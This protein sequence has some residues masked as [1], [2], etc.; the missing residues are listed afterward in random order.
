MAQLT[1]VYDSYDAVNVN[2]ESLHDIVTALNPAQ[3]PFLSMC[4]S[5][6]VQNTYHEWTADTL[7]G[8]AANAQIEGDEFTNTAITAP[9]RLFNYTQISSYVVS[10]TGTE[11][12]VATVGEDA[13]AYNLM[14]YGQLLKNDMEA[15]MLGNQAA[16]AG[17][18]N[19]V[20]ATRT[21]R[22][23][24]AWVPEANRD[25]N[26]TNGAGTTTQAATDGTTGQLRA[27]TEAQ[28]LNV[29]EAIY[30][31]GANPDTVIMHPNK[32]KIFS[33]FAGNGTRVFDA[34]SQ[35]IVAAVRIYVS[36]YG[37]VE[38][39]VDR[40]VRPTSSTVGRSVLVMDSS[41]VACGYLRPIAETPL[42]KTGDADRT[43]IVT[44][45]T[46]VAKNPS[47]LGVIA[48]LSA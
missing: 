10:V 43:A 17:T 38:A 27:F 42:A 18:N 34:K 9:S 45:Y 22:S 8:S 44:E 11:Q 16:A 28:F 23:F 48:D 15:I 32:A 2:K 13:K 14:K 20:S 1:N 5:Q 21:L 35:K 47:G 4:G 6:N 25:D 30:T 33:G 29:L 37:E 3:T 41:M 7:V 40:Y 26:V 12:A 31:A 24:E 19:S 39:Y 46:F 36:P